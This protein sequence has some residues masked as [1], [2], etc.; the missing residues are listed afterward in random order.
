MEFLSLV[1][2]TSTTCDSKD[3]EVYVV[4][5]NIFFFSV[6]TKQFGQQMCLLAVLLELWAVNAIQQSHSQTLAMK[7]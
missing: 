5:C 3:G 1:T 6:N 4:N 7:I 2:T